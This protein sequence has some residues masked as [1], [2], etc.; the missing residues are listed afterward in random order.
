MC[1]YFHVSLKAAI[2][3]EAV[4]F[5]IFREN[6]AWHFKWIAWFTWNMNPYSLKR[7]QKNSTFDCCSYTWPFKA[8]FVCLCWRFTAQSSKRLTSQRKGANDCRNYFMIKSQIKSQWMNVADLGGGRTRDFLV[9]SRTRI[10]LNHRGRLRITVYL[11]FV[12]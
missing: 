5:I 10:Q 9:S 12:F 4:S 11:L 2:T 6:K 8:Y 7:Y 3:T 1:T